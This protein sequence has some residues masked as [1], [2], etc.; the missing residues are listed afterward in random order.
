[1]ARDECPSAGRNGQLASKLHVVLA[2][3]CCSMYFVCHQKKLLL[4][5]GDV[6]DTLLH[7]V[8]VLFALLHDSAL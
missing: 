6:A 3:W 4:V 8:N 7:V 1:M 5:T 2:S